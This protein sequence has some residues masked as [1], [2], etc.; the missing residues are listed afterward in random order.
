MK[1]SHNPL[2]RLILNW[3]RYL[4]KSE[5]PLPTK[6]GST[7]EKERRILTRILTD[8]V[9]TGVACVSNLIRTSPSRGV[10]RE[11]E[12]KSIARGTVVNSIVALCNRKGIA[13]G[14]VVNPIMFLCNREKRHAFLCPYRITTARR[15]IA[16]CC[17]LRTSLC[18]LTAACVS[19]FCSQGTI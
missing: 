6:K 16:F 1:E 4:V 18:A 9:R 2:P 13:R 17:T 14:T 3:V 11:H 8:R 5:D 10:E 12:Q 7:S 19:R 15:V